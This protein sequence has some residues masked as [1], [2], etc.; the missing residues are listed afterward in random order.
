M[1]SDEDWADLQK[2]CDRL[3]LRHILHVAILE[4]FFRGWDNNKYTPEENGDYIYNKAKLLTN[5]L[6]DEKK[7]KFT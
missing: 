3:H 6:I 4:T 2:E 7:V 5:K 1:V